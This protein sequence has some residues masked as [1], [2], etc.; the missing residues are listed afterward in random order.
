MITGLQIGYARANCIHHARSLMT[1]HDR[2]RHYTHIPRDD[3][4][5][6]DSS[7]DNPHA[8]LI[9]L[10]ICKMYGFQF[11]FLALTMGYCCFDFHQPDLF[12]KSMRGRAG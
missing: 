1:Q 6:T 9:K 11:E 5:M 7:R 4:R 2:E 12:N 10:G 8:Y 3:V